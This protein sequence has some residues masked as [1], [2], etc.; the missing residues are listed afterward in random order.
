MIEDMRSYIRTLFN[1][2]VLSFLAMGFSS[3]LPLLLIGSTLKAWLFEAHVSLTLMGFF[4]LASLPYTLKFLW[5]PLLDRFIPP[6]LGRR[7][8]WI[9]ISQV[10]LA[11]ALAVLAFCNPAEG[12]RP[13]AILTF[14]IA[15]ISATQDIALDAYRREILLPAEFGFGNSVFITGY[16]LGMM[17]AGAFALFIA[18]SASWKIS[19]LCM[20]AA[21]S[22]GFVTTLF[23]PE[24][25]IEQAAP[26]TMQEAFI[27]PFLDYLK[28]RGAL[29]ILLFIVLYKVADVMATE[30][31]MPF[32]LTI[33]FTKTEVGSVVKVF[34]L[35]ATIIG[36]L[37]GGALL[38][39]LSLYQALWIFGILQASANLGF[40]WLSHVGPKIGALMA[41]ISFENFT[42]GMGAAA[43][44]TLMAS[45]TNKRYS[46]TQYALLSSLASLP[47][48]FLAAPTG[49]MAEHLGWPLFFLVCTS[50]AI[51]GLILLWYI[52]RFDVFQPSSTA[53]D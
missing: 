18:T 51:P 16:R 44:V 46:A 33:G 11:G 36:G 42:A 14:V 52:K 35:W 50:F 26:R 7:R 23:S 29:W 22:V 48:V 30:M 41:V 25:E 5:S 27:G 8:G 9:A 12:L 43:Y 6:F 19:Y 32:Y 20:A 28:R 3:G 1:W 4:S 53:I 17:F 37:A 21:V 49:Y 10:A 38:V 40:I 45:V 2:R 13:V 34:G 24:P 39:R 15:T 31:T 47:R